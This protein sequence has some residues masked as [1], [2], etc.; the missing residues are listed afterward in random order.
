M[1]N[2]ACFARPGTVLLHWAEEGED[3]AQHAASRA[4]LDVLKGSRD[5]RGRPFAVVKLPSPPPLR[6]TVAEADYGGEAA[7]DLTRKAGAPLPATYV[8]FYVANGGVVA[9][10]FGG[11]AAAR[12]AEALEVLRRE[13]PGRSVVG[14][15]CSRVIL[16]GGGNV[17]CS[18]MQQPV[19]PTC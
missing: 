8:N 9:P 15:P 17:H 18:T 7:G 4:A 3:A 12:D 13:F 1:D 6:R 10:Q 11:A 19:V 14:L 16:C 2:L 5:A